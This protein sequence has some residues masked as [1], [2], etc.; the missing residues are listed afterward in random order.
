M[1]IVKLC[2][3]DMR[4]DTLCPSTYYTMKSNVGMVEGCFIFLSS[5]YIFNSIAERDCIKNTRSD[6]A[7]G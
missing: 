6:G 5:R 4:I 2:Y 7:V 3:F 1:L